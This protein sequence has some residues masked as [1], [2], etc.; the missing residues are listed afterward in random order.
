MAEVPLSKQPASSSKYDYEKENLLAVKSDVVPDKTSDVAS[1][2]FNEVKVKAIHANSEQQMEDE[3]VAAV[4]EP[5]QELKLEEM[6][7][8]SSDS[9]ME[10]VEETEDVGDASG[11]NTRHRTIVIK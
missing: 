2:Q 1:R 7:E 6:F 8:A 5:K 10:S 3:N 9:Y 11:V 4:E